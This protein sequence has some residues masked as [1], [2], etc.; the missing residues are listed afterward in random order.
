VNRWKIPALLEQEVLSRDTRCVYCGVGFSVPPTTLGSRP[1][2]E[3]IV[4]DA[5][6][7]TRENIVRCCMSCNASKGTQNLR[8]WFRSDYCRRK[9]IT[10]STVAEIVRNA[11]TR[12]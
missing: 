9:G 8:A 5:A 10:E 12:V 11:L 6:I 4:N 7:V 1:S 3:H 2:W